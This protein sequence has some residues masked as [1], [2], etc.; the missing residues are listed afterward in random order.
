MSKVIYPEKRQEIMELINKD[1]AELGKLFDVM[2]KQNSLKKKIAI[3]KPVA[4]KCQQR[5]KIV[6]NIVN[7]IGCPNNKAIGSDGSEAVVILILHSEITM[8]KEILWIFERCYRENPGSIDASL[9]AMLADR[10]SIIE[11]RS[12]IYGT[13]WLQ[14]DVHGRFLVPIKKF[15]SVNK[16][17]KLL[18]LGDLTKLDPNNKNINIKVS[19]HDQKKI[20]E[21]TYMINFA[22]MNEK[23]V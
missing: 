12:Q 23:L 16:R 11:S 21:E 8:M 9:I 22:F 19:A 20:S 7:E 14:D 17:R 15:A 18:G 3:I 4:R 5:A 10:I 6:F 13:T 1:Q 2:P